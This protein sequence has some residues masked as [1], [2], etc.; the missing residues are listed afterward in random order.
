MNHWN[1]RFQ[2]ENYVYGTAPNEFIAE[3]HK[4]LDL[5][6]FDVL[7]I[8][9]GEGRNAVYLA[10]QGMNVTAWD[11]APSVAM[12]SGQKGKELLALKFIDKAIQF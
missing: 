5:K 10:E 6:A 7:A 12:V 9:E 11:Y 4:S 3:A 1:N 2:N 8:A